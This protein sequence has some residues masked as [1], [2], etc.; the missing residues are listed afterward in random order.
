M[1]GVENHFYDSSNYFFYNSHSSWLLDSGFWI[2]PLPLILLSANPIYSTHNYCPIVTGLY[3]Q[4]LC[5][6]PVNFRQGNISSTVS[7]SL[8]PVPCYKI[9]KSKILRKSCGINSDKYYG[10]SSIRTNVNCYWWCSIFDGGW[11]ARSQTSTK[12]SKESLKT[13]F[14][15]LIMAIIKWSPFFL[16]PDIKSGNI[17]IV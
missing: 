2:L 1:R 13:F 8:F 12:G 6:T 14:S 7:C 17:G 11:V 9:K 16:S 15:F 3:T 5:V 10:N 4:C